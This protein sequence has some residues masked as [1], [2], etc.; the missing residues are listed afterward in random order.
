MYSSPRGVAGW[1]GAGAGAGGPGTIG[2]CVVTRS[3]T[4]PLTSLYKPMIQHTTNLLNELVPTSQ[5]S[6]WNINTGSKE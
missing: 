4:R 3:R 6:Y 1:C 2:M 5:C